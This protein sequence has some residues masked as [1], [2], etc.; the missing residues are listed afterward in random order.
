MSR[1]GW[2]PN[3]TLIIMLKLMIN[4]L[5]TVFSSKIQIKIVFGFQ[6][7]EEPFSPSLNS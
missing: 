2:S 6:A 1:I 4:Y 5:S 7:K 3:K